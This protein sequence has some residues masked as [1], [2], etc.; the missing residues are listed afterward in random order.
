MAD[1]DDKVTWVNQ[2]QTK[3]KSIA[4]QNVYTGPATKRAKRDAAVVGQL[5]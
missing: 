1:V 4:S 2:L 3:T 5:N